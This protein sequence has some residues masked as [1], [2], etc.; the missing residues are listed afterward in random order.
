M[1]NLPIS[2]HITVVST[3]PSAIPDAASAASGAALA[4]D[5][6]DFSNLL[7]GQL[8]AKVDALA[9]SQEA[10][11]PELASGEAVPGVPVNVDPAATGA[12]L[13]VI[14][15]IPLSD[16]PLA[17][18]L[19]ESGAELGKDSARLELGR[20]LA[21]LDAR[22]DGAARV[23]T[24]VPE[25]GRQE[26]L[27]ANFA[28]QPAVLPLKGLSEAV[29]EALISEER[30][31]KFLR[32]EISEAAL[33]ERAP[34]L[35]AH[36]VVAAKTDVVTSAQPTQVPAVAVESRIGAPGWGAELSQKVVWLANQQQQVAQINVT[37]PQLGPIEIRLNL[38]TDQASAIFV[39]PH[40]S[41]RDAIEAALPRLREMLAE[42][43]LN[44][45][46]VD[47]S[48]QSFGQPQQGQAQSGDR[49]RSIV[50]ELAAAHSGET[51]LHIGTIAGAARGGQGLVDIFA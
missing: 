16:L 8:A 7:A 45:G 29:R 35:L 51:G 46:N 9:S 33:L 20:G 21:L 25:T 6:T 14:G 39:S 42:N 47:V 31:G 1:G 36:G 10:V 28:A 12:G 41:V 40:A 44:L 11:A 24:L 22:Q 18:A 3:T 32:P 37:P 23:D 30:G 13:A 17:A 49:S 43:G 38:S 26:E 27:P 50:P 5:G 15:Y 4:A 48:A 19:K 34:G 2:A